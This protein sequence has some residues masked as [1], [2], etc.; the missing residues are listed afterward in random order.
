MRTHRFI[1]PTCTAAGELARCS[2]E[3]E[4]DAHVPIDLLGTGRIA[5]VAALAG[6]SFASP[7]VLKG[8]ALASVTKHLGGGAAAK[9]A[10]P[11]EE[12]SAG[13]FG[14][15]LPESWERLGST[16]ATSQSDRGADQA[17]TVITAV[18]PGT[19]TGS[20]CTDGVQVTFIVYRGGTGHELPLV[21]EFDN[22]L[23]AQLPKRLA[24]FKRISSEPTPAAD[25]TRWLRYE[26][27]YTAAGAAKHEVLG[28]YRHADGS[29]V[30]AVA[31]G[32][33]KAYTVHAAEISSFLAGAHEVETSS[34]AAGTA[35][36]AS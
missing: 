32:P 27:G 19:S 34:D 17:G 11:T 8:D 26:F 6:A 4:P 33:S 16:A 10:E 21:T 24:G 28:A 23:S 1:A 7:V 36:A 5:A 13:G 18:C 2:P 20:R 14:F 25:G 15:A 30:V 12:L 22:Q 9:V 31:T 29:G 35:D 3:W